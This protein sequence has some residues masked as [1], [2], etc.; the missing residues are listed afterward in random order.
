[1]GDPYPQ[2]PSTKRRNH[3]PGF[4]LRTVSHFFRQIILC[5]S[6]SAHSSRSSRLRNA[7]WRKKHKHHKIG[8]AHAGNSS[9]SHTRQHRHVDVIIL[10]TR[11][12]QH[13]PIH[14][15]HHN[16]VAASAGCSKGYNLSLARIVAR[17]C[18]CF[19]ARIRASCVSHSLLTASM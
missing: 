15:H 19:V 10:S 11:H 13:L 9:E 6:R 5:R 12:R 17:S 14:S 16:S 3:N 7:S 2:E 1:M 18:Y 8:V 4:A